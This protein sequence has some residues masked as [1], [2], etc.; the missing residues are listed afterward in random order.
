MPIFA[1]SFFA[2]SSFGSKCCIFIGR[3]GCRCFIY[4]NIYLWTA[5]A[6]LSIWYFATRV[7]LYRLSPLYKPLCRNI[8]RPPSR[9][10]TACEKNSLVA[11]NSRK[12]WKELDHNFPRLFI[13]FFC[14]NNFPYRHQQSDLF[15]ALKACLG[16]I[17]GTVSF[18]KI[19]R[20]EEQINMNPA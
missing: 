12:T 10:F 4:L 16:V 7:W 3:P 14:D 8:L 2:V 6:S 9:D 1:E 19:E 5:D 15:F 17:A 18:L 11:G 20:R 13:S